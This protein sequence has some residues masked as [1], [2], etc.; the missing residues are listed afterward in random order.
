MKITSFLSRLKKEDIRTLLDKSNVKK[1]RYRTTKIM[2]PCSRRAGQ[3]ES[4]ELHYA[5]EEPTNPEVTSVIGQ[6]PSRTNQLK[7]N[8][9]SAKKICQSS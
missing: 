2:D 7:N 3:W 9:S 5:N 4:A 1:L 6:E 8:T